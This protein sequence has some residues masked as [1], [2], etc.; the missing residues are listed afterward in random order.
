MPQRPQPP[1]EDP[2]VE[3]KRQS[4][5]DR[6]AKAKA[7]ASSAPASSLINE[8]LL[9]LRSE[10]AIILEKPEEEVSLI[11]HKDGLYDPIDGLMIMSDKNRHDSAE[12]LRIIC[13]RYADMGEKLR[14]ICVFDGQGNHSNSKG[15][16]L[17][18]LV[19]IMMLSPSKKAAAIRRLAA[20]T[21]CRVLG[22]DVGLAKQI[23]EINRVQDHMKINE[24][25][26]PARVFGQYVKEQQQQ[27]D[28]RAHHH[29][30]AEMEL[31]L[32]HK[33]RMME[34]EYE[35]AQKKA[36]AEI[37]KSEA[38]T[39]I[40]QAEA[41]KGQAE[42]RRTQ[43][44]TYVS[45][46]ETVARLGVTPDDRSRMQLR[47]LVGSELGA[48]AALQTRKEISVRNFLI[49]KKVKPK[50]YETKFGKALAKLKRNDLCTKGLS[51]V[52]PTKMI[53]ANG[54]VVEAKMYFEEDLPLFELAWGT[55]TG[56]GSEE[57]CE[58]SGSSILSAFARS[59]R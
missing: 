13:E 26:H 45:C 49:S 50:E 20:V 47:D 52:L 11:K 14:H 16:D 51:V 12:D 35:T 48:G 9:Q 59:S 19:E 41:L 5:R 27:K 58:P 29:C 6:R 18:T 17:P 2:E 55:L 36:R 1:H 53:E 28:E 8:K 22:G 54:Q 31:I 43:V 37:G 44:E 25:P 7:K 23:L 15:C 38:E 57:I 30:E 32:G 39:Q 4:H 40:V 21:L 42:A 33:K 34:L 46:F 24:I 3:R 56:G 10:L